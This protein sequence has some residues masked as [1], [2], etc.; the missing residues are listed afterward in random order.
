MYALAAGE[1]GACPTQL[2]C[3][4]VAASIESISS[5]NDTDSS[6]PAKPRRPAR[7]PRGAPTLGPGAASNSLEL[8][9]KP[10]QRTGIWLN[11]PPRAAV[12]HRWSVPWSWSCPTFTRPCSPFVLEPVKRHNGRAKSTFLLCGTGAL[13][14]LSET[15]TNEVLKPVLLTTFHSLFA[16]LAARCFAF[17]LA[18]TASGGSSCRSS[19]SAYRP[20]GKLRQC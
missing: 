20:K 18:Q 10:L 9:S 13:A 16:R 3:S 17:D 2:D 7:L 12:P 1:G 11:R 19:V 6:D 14:G 4:R 8:G 15:N 5:M